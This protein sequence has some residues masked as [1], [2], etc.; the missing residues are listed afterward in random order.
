[1]RAVGE[2]GQATVETVAL[3]PLL[4]LL[5]AFVWQAAVAGQAVWLAGSAARAAARAAALGRDPLPAARSVLPGRLDPG[6]RVGRV[7]GGGV[8][9]RLAVP[10]VIGGARLG[11]VSARARLQPQAP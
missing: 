5:V 1:M 2:R 3:L 6:A 11:T 7:G 8:R 10:S 9:V 4:V